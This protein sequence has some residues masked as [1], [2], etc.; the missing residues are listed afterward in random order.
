MKKKIVAFL[1]ISTMAVTMVTGCGSDK[2][3]EKASTETTTET[4][5]EEDYQFVSAADAVTAAQAGDIHVLDVREWDKYVSGRIADSQW[6]PIFPLEDE[7]LAEAMSTYAKEKLNDGKKIYIV[8]NSGQ[9]G[10]QKATKIFKEAGIDDSLIFTVK[11]GAKALAEEAG[12]LTTSRIDEKINWQYITGS[13]ATAAV[14]NADIQFLDVRDDESY[15]SGHLKGSLQC[16]LKEVEDVNAQTAMYQL[17]TE[18]L[19]KEKPVYLLCF[20]G[21]KCAKTGISIMKDAGF[22]TDKLYIIENGAKDAD[23]QAALV[24]D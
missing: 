8:C 16:N 7:S 13:E 17:A 14:G 9:R 21:N 10:A 23:I 20:S 5:K 6:C 3:E 2:K 1:L 18:T 11:D 24:Q 22:D 12:A 4:A 19:D 15:A